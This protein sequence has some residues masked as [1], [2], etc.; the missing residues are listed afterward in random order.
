MQ[1]GFVFL[2]KFGQDQ[3]G[4]I[5]KIR[6]VLGL[7]Q[8]ARQDCGMIMHHFVRRSSKEH[9]NT[10][11]KCICSSIQV[12]VRKHPENNIPVIPLWEPLYLSH[13]ASDS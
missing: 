6:H 11:K 3:F 5:Y 12:W 13:D 9:V 10:F 2:E 7:E 4:T 1:K 8:N